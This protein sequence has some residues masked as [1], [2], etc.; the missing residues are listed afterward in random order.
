MKKLLALGMVSCLSACGGTGRLSLTAWGEEY[1]EEEIPAA[2]FEDGYTVRFTKFL[3]VVNEFQLATKTGET[4]PRQA[5]PALID[6]HKPGPVELERFD[7]VPAQKWDSVSWAIMPS[8]DAVAVGEVSGDDVTRMKTEGYSLYVEGNV[9]KGAV[10]KTFAWGF[11]TDTRYSECSND[12]LGEGVTVPTG[13]TVDVQL[14]IHGDHLWYDD[15]QSPD[16]K[17]RGEAIVAADADADGTVTLAE[18]AAVPL[19]TLPVGQYGTGGASQVKTLA[20]FVTALGRTV[21][22]FRGEGECLTTPR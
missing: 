13:G 6:V 2:E 22:H 3:V 12:D 4:G 9:S 11:K 18:L 16:A 10:S 1:I 8:A 14:T 17:L 20:D 19:T 21:G 15:L 5:K 7:D